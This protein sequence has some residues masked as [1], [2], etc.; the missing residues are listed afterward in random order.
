VSADVTAESSD[1]DSHAVTVYSTTWCGYCHRLK[2]QLAQAG[3]D[4]VD[5]DI[6]RDNQAAG[7]VM[8]LNAGSQTVPTL[9]FADGSSLTNPTLNQVLDHLAGQQPGPRET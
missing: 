4:F 8:S 1:A 9:R 7:Y 6:E 3:I 5:V 2:R